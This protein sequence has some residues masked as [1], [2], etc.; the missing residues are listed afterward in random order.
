MIG[1]LSFFSKINCTALPCL[2]FV[3]SFRCCWVQFP[4]RYRRCL[5]ARGNISRLALCLVRI[6]LKL[7]PGSDAVL[8]VS[9][10][11]CKWGR[12]KDFAHL[13]SIR[14]MWSTALELGLRRFRK[15]TFMGLKSGP[16]CKYLTSISWVSHK[17]SQA[18]IY[19]LE[20]SVWVAPQTE[21]V[22]VLSKMLALNKSPALLLSVISRQH[23]NNNSTITGQESAVTKILTKPMMLYVCE[24]DFGRWC[25]CC[26][27]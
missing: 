21:K 13:H 3:I 23:G 6:A 19:W 2:F 27:T 25:W 24:G 8:H 11:E 7:R 14:F 12:T 5:L 9:R 16:C 17:L 18:G 4:R 1:F 15:P 22:I 26:F 10:I 20:L